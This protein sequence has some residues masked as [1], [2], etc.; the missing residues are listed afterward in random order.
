[1][2]R[3]AWFALMLLVLTILA[4]CSSASPPPAPPPPE[5][6][7]GPTTG[8]ISGVVRVMTEASSAPAALDPSPT[9]E[10]WERLSAQAPFRAGEILV[11]FGPGPGTQALSALS[12]AGVV[13]EVVES[14]PALGVQLLANPALEAV[15]TLRLVH[16]LQQ[17][18]DVRYAHPNY[19]VQTTA[20]PNDAF[21]GFQWHYPAIG[22]EAAWDITT[23]SA[24]I[25]VAVVDTG[26]LHSFS[27][28]SSTHPDLVGK[29]VPGYDFISDARIA[30]DG[31]GR[32]GDP[33]DDGDEGAGQSSY[34][35][36]HVAGT[37]AAATNNRVGVAGVDWHAKVLPIRALGAGGGTIFDVIEGTLWA[38]GLSITGVPDN[39][40]PA[41]V[42]NLSLGG[43]Y[44]CTTFE[45][46]AFDWIA[47]SSPRRAIVVVAAGNNDQDA[48]LSS[49]ASC[50]NVITVGATD[51]L[52][53][54]APYS[55]YGARID[56]MAPGGDMSVDHNA[57]SYRDG[58]LSLWRDDT[59][60]SFGYAFSEGTS[61]AAPH[62]AGVASL[63][64]SI[65]PDLTQSQVLAAL[66]A[67]A[68]PL[69]ASD[70]GRPTGGDC[71]AGL[72]DAAAA[73][74]L[75]RD[76]AIP[77][78][79]AGDLVLDPGLLDFGTRSVSL[80]VTLRNTGTTDLTWRAT[81]LE[82]SAGN[83]APLPSDALLISADS[84]TI[85]A[86]ASQLVTLSLARDLVSED[87]TYTLTVPFEVDGSD[88][89]AYLHVS[90][91]QATGASPQ[92][93]GP[94][95]VAAF[96]EDERGELVVSGSVSADTAFSE[97]SFEALP[98]ANE[99]IAWSDEND[100][101]LI[102]A[103]DYLGV[104]PGLV[105]LVAGGAATGVDIDVDQ[106]V[107]L[108][109]AP[110]RDVSL[111]QGEAWHGLLQQLSVARPR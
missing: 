51:L 50:S 60:G 48:G 59:T 58:V 109:L 5:Q 8:T 49:P 64:K 4:A 56:V 85:S 97:Y 39:A 78:S 65:A 32:D 104:F 45:Q 62:V 90:F 91:I 103:G 72:I 68:Q 26:I 76:D 82:S 3:R 11:A 71:G 25:I 22:L 14:V 6:G 44:R 20:V 40:N 10:S 105:Q 46:D 2:V 42:I 87:G 83:P 99:V 89:V 36:T 70:C 80:G 69:S 38:A 19:L 106:V 35:G 12:V 43:E 107:D 93:T 55:N 47:A 63:M 30:G 7:A 13:L 110:R 23:G 101:G 84:G 29:V 15:Q 21:Y 111:F 52:G 28:A 86:S 57:D 16:E 73:L 27:D 1:M 94:M 54:R 66:S 96:I 31:D 41:H 67:T 95:V 102:D 33:Y 100:N 88:D 75:V 17:R 53:N 108:G 24:D 98:G 81:A 37:I 18:P 61:M 34:H 74:A 79:G 9:G 77:E 92:L